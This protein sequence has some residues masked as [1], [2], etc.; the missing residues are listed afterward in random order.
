MKLPGSRSQLPWNE[1]KFWPAGKMWISTA[2]NVPSGRGFEVMPTPTPAFTS[3]SDFFTTPRTVA[4]SLSFSFTSVFSRVLTISR[5]PSTFSIV[6][7]TR[8]FC[9]CAEVTAK[10]AANAA[11]AMVL[12]IVFIGSSREVLLWLHCSNA[13]AANARRATGRA[14]RLRHEVAAADVDAFRLERAAGCRL[15]G[16]DVD[17]GAGLQIAAGAVQS[18]QDDGVRHDQD[19]LLAVLVL[20]DQHLTVDALHRGIDGG[21]GHGGAGLVPRAVPFAGAAL[22]FREDHDPDRLQRTVSLGLGAHADERSRLDVGDRALADGENLGLVG[23]TDLGIAALG[24]D[25]EDVSFQRGELAADAHRLVLRRSGRNRRDSQKCRSGKD[26]DGMFHVV[27]SG[28]SRN[29]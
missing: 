2:C 18:Q 1:L 7:R 3:A 23:K 19:L 12:N 5:S 17:V 29:T 28:K 27:S 26:L 14:C 22:R 21:V 20:D 13:R 6:P 9:A 11:R 8:T 25:G 15:G 4:L 10:A 24:V 16:R